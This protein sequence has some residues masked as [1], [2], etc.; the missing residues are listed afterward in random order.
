MATDDGALKLPLT[1]GD[2]PVKS[3]SALRADR[4]TRTATLITA[5][6]SSSYVHSPVTQGA[7]Y[8][9]HRLLGIV[10]DMTHVGGHHVQ[11]EM[12][13]HAAQLRGTSLVGGDLRAQVGQVDLGVAGWVRRPAQHLKRLCLAQHAVPHQQPV[14]DEHPLLLH[15]GAECGHRAR[16][17]PADLGMVAARCDEEQDAGLASS[18]AAVP[19]TGVTTVTSGKWVP[20]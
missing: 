3:I 20:P 7:E 8:A 15:Y 9:A 11:P 17:D 12:L 10:L 18:S 16:R 14:V 5:P 13:A 1:C 19:N 4:S 6:L 2:V